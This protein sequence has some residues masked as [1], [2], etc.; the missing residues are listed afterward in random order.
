MTA[1]TKH[2]FSSLTSV[3]FIY[4]VIHYVEKYYKYA[5]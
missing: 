4:E 1:F 2:V 5:V 3:L